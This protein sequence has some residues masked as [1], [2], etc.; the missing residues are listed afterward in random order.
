[1]KKLYELDAY[2]N[3][4]QLGSLSQVLFGINLP[5]YHPKKRFSWVRSIFRRSQQ[6]RFSS[7]MSFTAWKFE[8]DKVITEEFMKKDVEELFKEERVK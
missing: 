7:A 5:S 4:N 1:M 6:K 2:L 3:S 8:K